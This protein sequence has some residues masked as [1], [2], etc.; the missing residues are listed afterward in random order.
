LTRGGLC[1][2]STRIRCHGNNNDNIKVFFL[3]KKPKKMTKKE[4]KTLMNGE[5]G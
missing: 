2:E 4:K 1:G 3:K 5:N